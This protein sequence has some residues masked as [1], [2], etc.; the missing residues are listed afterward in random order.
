MIRYFI[1]RRFP[2]PVTDKYNQQP[3]L[4]RQKKN[5]TK[6]MAKIE[7]EGQVKDGG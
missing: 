2:A 6:K 7:E 1:I 4:G 3:K 5:F